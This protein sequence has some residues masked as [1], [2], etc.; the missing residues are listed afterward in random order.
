M[1]KKRTL[2]YFRGTF[3][4]GDLSN[5]IGHWYELEGLLGFQEIVS[6]H[7]CFTYSTL[8]MRRLYQDSRWLNDRR[9]FVYSTRMHITTERITISRSTPSVV[10]S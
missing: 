8:M 6:I 5:V 10:R 9:S 7:K 4:L 3:K 2:D 1:K